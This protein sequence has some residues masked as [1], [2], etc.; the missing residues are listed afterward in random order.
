MAKSTSPPRGIRNNNPG[1]ILR[2]R[3]AWQGE[4]PFAPGDDVEMEVFLTPPA[5]IRAIVK[6]L[7]TYQSEHK[8]KTVEAMISRWCPPFHTFP[9]GRKVKQD[10]AAYVR[11][12]AAEIGVDPAARIS[13]T[14]PEIL[15]PMLKAIIKQEN[16]NQQPYSD[17]V[18]DEAMRLAGINTGAA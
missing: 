18:L 16:A 4:K 7:R 5:G 17:A 13:I 1:N 8:L 11:R 10:T 14:S 3:T 12:V 2:S 15:R 6:V 9:D